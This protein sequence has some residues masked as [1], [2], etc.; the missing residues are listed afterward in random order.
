[1]KEKKEKNSTKDANQYD[2]IIKENIDAVFIS[3]VIS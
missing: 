1:M 2:K 3:F